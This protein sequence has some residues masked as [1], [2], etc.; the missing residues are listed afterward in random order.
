MSTPLTL[1]RHT[2]RARLERSELD[3]VLDTIPVGTLSTVVDGKPWVVPMMFAR[4]GDE[5]LL[6]GST[7]AGALRQVA[8]GAPAAFSVLAIDG[9]VVAA[10]T[11]NSSANY[12]SAVVYGSL[13]TLE[14]DA[15]WE[16]LDRFSDHIIPGRVAEVRP[17]TKKE[18]AATL[19]MSLPIV[20]GRWMVKVRTGPPS[21][22]EPDAPVWQGVVPIRTVAGEPEPAPWV[23]DQPIPPS[24]QRLVENAWG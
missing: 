13:T 15:K 18:S 7:G 12:R 11:F 1:N 2:E 6:H 14:G 24:V 4:L 23:R 21:S 9:V 8:A 3:A 20:D 16:A 5:I 22:E 17:M 19:A 10:S